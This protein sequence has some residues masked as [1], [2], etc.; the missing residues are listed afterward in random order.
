MSGPDSVPLF[1]AAAA[2][3]GALVNG[4]LGYGFS[5]IVVPLAIWVAPNRILSPALVLVEVFINLLALAVNARAVPTVGRRM[6]PLL[7]GL[8]PGAALGTAALARTD[9]STLCLATYGFLLPLIV[10][11]TAGVRWPIRREALAGLPLGAGVGALYATTTISGPPLALLLNNQGFTPPQFRAGLSLFRV[12][13]SL[14]T[15]ALYLRAGLFTAESLHL[16]AAVAPSIAIG[17]PLGALLLR[18]VPAEAFRRVCM[19]VDGLLVSLALAR[20][21]G[22][23]G[24]P[25]SWARAE[26][27]AV[28]LLEAWLLGRYFRAP[29][30]A[31]PQLIPVSEV[32]P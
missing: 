2:L 15:A 28:A 30:P 32:R 23:L 14:L 10:L 31:S 24:V 26:V 20:S 12:V 5:S 11:Q 8:V 25:S 27:A 3:L 6:L 22:A 29:P 7:A 13:E 21:L 1:L 9:P 19:G 4:G 17:L 18:R 16:A